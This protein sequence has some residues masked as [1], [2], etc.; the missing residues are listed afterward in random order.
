VRSQGATLVLLPG[1]LCDARLWAPQIAVLGVSHDLYVAD[2]T[3]RESIA[4]MAADVLAATQGP[5]AVAGLS[6]GGY[7]AMEMALTAPDRVQRLA[8]LDTS[9]RPDPPEKARMRAEMLKQVEHGRFRGVT[10]RL[11][12]ALIHPDRLDDAALVGTVTAM[13]EAVGREAFVRQ[14]RAVTTR[15]DYRPALP[16]IACPTLVLCGR[17]DMRTPLDHSEEL[18]AGIPAARLVVFEAC[19][20]LSTIERPTAVTAALADWL[21]APVP[22]SP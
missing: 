16:R 22:T 6:M 9:A 17:E 7:V 4:A 11:L 19:G 12:P 18:A 5:L 13:T 8:L 10:R 3:R 2:L 15:R 21:A 14:T 1:L 20:H